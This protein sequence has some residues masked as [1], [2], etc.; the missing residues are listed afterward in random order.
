MKV[1]IPVDEKKADTTICQSFGR[2][3]F[4]MLYDSETKDVSFIDNLAAASQGGAGIK[5]AQAIA[6]SGAKAVVTYRCGENAAE[7]LLAADVKLYKARGESAMD[8]AVACANGALTLLAEIHPG[9]HGH[10]G[11]QA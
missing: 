5:A 11:A 3:P 6:D 2:T 7:V 8:N 10:K 1:A 9:F 4:Y